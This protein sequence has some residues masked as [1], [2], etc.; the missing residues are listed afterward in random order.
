[1]RFVYDYTY[2]IVGNAT[3]MCVCVCE[4]VD[5]AFVHPYIY[6]WIAFVTRNIIRVVAGESGFD[7]GRVFDVYVYACACDGPVVCDRL[8]MW[9]VNLVRVCVR[10][11][12]WK[13]Q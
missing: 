9:T 11:C 13:N 4:G 7:C 1:M 12:L 5:Y 8:S 10:V 6:I 3:M 2:G